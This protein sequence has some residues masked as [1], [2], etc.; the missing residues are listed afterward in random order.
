MLKKTTCVQSNPTIT[1]RLHGYRVHRQ[2]KANIFSNRNRRGSKGILGAV[3]LK[4]NSASDLFSEFTS[5]FSKAGKAVNGCKLGR[6]HFIKH[7]ACVCMCR[8]THSFIVEVELGTEQRL[9]EDDPCHYVYLLPVGP[10]QVTSA[11]YT[12]KNKLLLV[13]DLPRCCCCRG[14]NSKLLWWCTISTICS[15]SDRAPSLSK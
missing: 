5:K 11:Q 10:F 6:R 13:S 7:R 2:L 3:F 14:G 1:N 8:L 9:Y 4:S 12:D 15:H